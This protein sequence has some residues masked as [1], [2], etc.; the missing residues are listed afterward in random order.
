MN[1]APVKLTPEF[2]PLMIEKKELIDTDHRFKMNGNTNSTFAVEIKN[3][4]LP[5]I[6]SW[7]GS[8]PHNTV[9]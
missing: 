1:H 5:T 3:L 4:C 2:C 6:L 8:T 9:V 7:E